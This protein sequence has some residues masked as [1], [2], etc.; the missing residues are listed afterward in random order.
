MDR[1]VVETTVKQYSLKELKCRLFVLTCWGPG[2]EQG[3]SYLNKIVNTVLG[4]C[5]SCAAVTA[6]SACTTA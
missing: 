5:I 4:S 1:E 3:M 2:Q 6:W